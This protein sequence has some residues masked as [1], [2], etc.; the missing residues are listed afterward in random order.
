MNFMV[1]NPSTLFDRVLTMMGKS[2][3]ADLG[4]SKLLVS[5]LSDTDVSEMIRHQIYFLLLYSPSSTA[6]IAENIPPHSSIISIDVNTIRSWTPEERCAIV[7]HE[8]G[9]IL[10]NDP[11]LALNSNSPF[12]REFLADNFAIEKGFGNAIVT[13]LRRGIQLNPGEFDKES[14]HE[15]IRRIL[16]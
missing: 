16:Q 1:S 8:L 15:R 2:A 10:R 6:N 13:G 3:F 7:L 4:L 9:H 12:T 11:G 5:A 14:T